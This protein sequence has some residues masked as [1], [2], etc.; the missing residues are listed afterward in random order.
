[1]AVLII[2]PERD[3]VFLAT[4]SGQ[5]FD[6]QVKTETA[7]RVD[8]GEGTPGVS[9]VVRPLFIQP[10]QSADKDHPG[11]LKI[12]SLAIVGDKLYAGTQSRGIV[13]VENGEAKEIVSK[14]RSYFIN[15][16]QT[17]GEG[18]LWVGAQARGED[19]GLLDSGDPLK[20]TKIA[21]QTGAVTA[22]VRGT[23][24]DMW[25]AT[26]GHGAVRLDNGKP[27]ER[28]TFERHRGALRSDP[29]SASSLTPKR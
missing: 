16:L 8:R 6:C 23:G 20:P 24:N 19:S 17:D 29:S 5:I 25:I 12:T 7:S 27:V 14:P 15:A 21:A 22:I 26:D 1:M 13:V 10:L 11:P 9:F 4:D 28:L 3:R 2:A 18:K